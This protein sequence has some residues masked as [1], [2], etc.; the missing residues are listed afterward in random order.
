MIVLSSSK[1]PL[2]SHA[3]LCQFEEHKFKC[4]SHQCSICGKSFAA[5][6]LL[7]LHISELHDSYFAVACKKKPLYCCLVSNC[8]EQFWSDAERR[9][10]L[11]QRHLFHPSYD[12]HNPKKFLKKL[13][14]QAA[15]GVKSPAKQTPVK[16][17][18][19]QYP[20][21]APTTTTT[22]TPPV[23][24]GGG[25]RAQRRA[26]KFNNPERVGSVHDTREGDKSS[27]MELVHSAAQ[28]KHNNDSASRDQAA[29]DENACD[30]SMDIE[31][32]IDAI[33]NTL[34]A[35]RIH[36]PSKISFGRRKGHH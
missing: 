22:T 6:R 24:A 8:N 31:L 7:S 36:V 15:D 11:I 3:T 13:K 16:P 14:K 35:T 2:L 32:D 4:H 20:K 33:T 27:Q 25:N 26:T 1:S 29:T 23:G 10:H 21:P 9:D 17:P 30:D 12:F 28:R 18:S 34:Q 5:D 19:N